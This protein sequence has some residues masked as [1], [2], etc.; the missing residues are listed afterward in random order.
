VD[1]P[2]LV[3]VIHLTTSLGGAPVGNDQRVAGSI[4]VQVKRWR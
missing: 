4:F 2:F 1:D 3:P